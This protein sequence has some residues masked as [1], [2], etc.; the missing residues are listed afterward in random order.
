GH[1]E[2]ASGISQL[3]KVILQFQHQIL[4]PSI[5]ASPINSNIKLKDTPFYIQE[6]S[7]PWNCVLDPVSGEHLPRRSVINSFGA[8]GAYV[9]LIM[10][11]Y[12]KAAKMLSADTTDELLF[13]FSAKTKWSLWKYLEEMQAFL[14][15]KLA[16]PLNDFSS[17]LMKINHN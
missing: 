12:A 9:T 5:N 2:A 13:I 14:R 11:A 1:L 16:S 6:K 10:E 8:G 15:H 3:T 17:H 7:S 4:V